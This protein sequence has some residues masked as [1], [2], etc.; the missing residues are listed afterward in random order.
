MDERIGQLLL[1]AHR[2]REHH[3][4]E[5]LRRQS[6]RGGRLGTN[7]VEVGAVTL[8]VLSAALAA[9]RRL[10]LA[11]FDEI[12]LASS[13]ALALLPAS[14]ASQLMAIPLSA[15]E[16]GVV[17]AVASPWD[18]AIVQ[19]LEAA[20]GR[21]LRLKVAPELRIFDALEKLYRLPHP[22][23]VSAKAR[24]DTTSSP[25]PIPGLEPLD[26]APPLAGPFD[27]ALAS[28]L[29]TGGLASTAVDDFAGDL[30]LEP[31]PTAAAPALHVPANPVALG[32][33][34]ASDPLASMSWDLPASLAAPAAPP[35][36]PW[37]APAPTPPAPSE[38][39][40]AADIEIDLEE[41]D[42]LPAPVSP[43][44]PPARPEAPSSSA[45][46]AFTPPPPPRPAATPDAV[47][48]PAMPPTSAATTPPS[49]PHSTL[50]L[51]RVEPLA[52][53]A[54]SEPDLLATASVAEAWGPPAVE[55]RPATSLYMVED[56]IARASRT[57]KVVESLLWG[58][59]GRFEAAVFFVLD[60]KRARARDGFGPNGPV[61][62][63]DGFSIDL[64]VPSL[65]SSAVDRQGFVI[66]V[67]VS[68]PELALC[69]RMGVSP[70]GVSVV[71]PFS[72]HGSFVSALWASCGSLG[73][74]SSLAS[75]VERL[76]E[77][78]GSAFAR[79][80]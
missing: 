42:E 51:E 45:Q 10:P 43:L 19:A 72:M 53:P 74:L 78:G 56:A 69:A 25:G 2:I 62:F 24:L 76:S 7:L 17:V 1:Q 41:T 60:G 18:P 47:Q 55:R 22:R 35:Q 80:G 5:A 12:E 40:E 39:Q 16:A 54:T 23:R 58:C 27:S 8:E 28:P 68:Q 66:E 29:D 26:A 71:I 20:I 3:L 73:Q 59:E 37:E 70:H 36:T 64:A 33:A 34:S 49:P 11:T 75:D 38:V 50:E 48:N 30:L 57:E 15:G 4:E 67:P 79:L 14:Q 31:T 21:P 44:P 13:E 52:P 77:L 9:Q 32:L 63:D 61:P 46:P 65:F 6:E